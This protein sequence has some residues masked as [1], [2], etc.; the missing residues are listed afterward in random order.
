MKR[1]IAAALLLCACGDAPPE[2]RVSQAP[3]VL[4][5]GVPQV[6][7]VRT[8]DSWQWVTREQ[9][10]WGDVQEDFL[11]AFYSGALR[12]KAQAAGALAF[13]TWS[14]ANDAFSTS[15]A[16]EL[17][18]SASAAPVID[19]DPSVGFAQTC[20]LGVFC[21]IAMYECQADGDCVAFDVQQ[22]YAEVNRA[23]LPKSYGEYACIAAEYYGCMF[24]MPNSGRDARAYCAEQLA[25]SG[26]VVDVQN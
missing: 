19:F 15:A 25:A 22:C 14:S 26:L 11:G 18:F 24:S 4:G 10:L 23:E 2:T 20:D 21:D 7:W 5:D 1:L 17:E 6:A 8:S 13:S 12:F 16:G 9:P 3:L